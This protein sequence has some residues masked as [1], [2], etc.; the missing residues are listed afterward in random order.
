[1][2][3]WAGRI[4]EGERLGLRKIPGS[5]FGVLLPSALDYF[6]YAGTCQAFLCRFLN[7]IKCRVR[8]VEVG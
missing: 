5:S 3:F 7:A 8:V 6:I 1:M 2:G 4:S